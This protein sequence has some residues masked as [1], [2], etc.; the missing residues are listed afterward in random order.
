M[1]KAENTVSAFC[2]DVLGALDGVEL[3]TL[4]AKGEI[5]DYNSTFFLLAAHTRYCGYGIWYKNGDTSNIQKVEDTTISIEI[6]FLYHH[7]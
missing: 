3:G 7:C 5:R 4:I 2:D 1:D 6:L